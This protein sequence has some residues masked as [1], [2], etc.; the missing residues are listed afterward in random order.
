LFETYV[1][2]EDSPYCGEAVFI[3]EGKPSVIDPLTL[4]IVELDPMSTT[5]GKNPANANIC[6]RSTVIEFFAD[7]GD[8]TVTNADLLAAMAGGTF[9][10]G[11]PADDAAT[12]YLHAVDFTLGHLGDEATDGAFASTTC[13]AMVTD[14]GR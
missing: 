6:T 7:A 8:L 9:D 13:D 14:V 12:V 5:V 11:L 4:E 1:T 3:C 2:N 10:N